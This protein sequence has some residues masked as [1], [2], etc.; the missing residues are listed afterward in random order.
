MRQD[1]LPATGIACATRSSGYGGFACHTGYWKA[2]ANRSCTLGSSCHK[3]GFS[4]FSRFLGGSFAQNANPASGG[5]VSPAGSGSMAAGISVSALI[6]NPVDMHFQDGSQSS[7]H[8]GGP[9]L[10]A[11]PGPTVLPHRKKPPGGSFFRERQAQ[12]A[13]RGRVLT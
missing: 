3:S 1:T 13:R 5:A 7:R 4:G 12:A 2:P 10:P 6:G 8:H 11:A 9:A